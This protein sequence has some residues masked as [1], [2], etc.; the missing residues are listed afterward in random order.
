[1][2]TL[3]MQCVVAILTVLWGFLAVQVWRR[4]PTAPELHRASWALTGWVFT[5]LGISTTIQLG[6]GAPW[7]YFSGE[8]STVY[9]LYLRLSP[10]G[11]HSRGFLVI[12]YGVM[13]AGLPW[14]WRVARHRF[15]AVV[16]LASCAAM[17]V[18]ALVGWV[19]G[20]LV[21]VIHWTATAIFDSVELMLLLLAL[22]VAVVWNT[23]D[24]LLWV[25]LAIFAVHE[26]LDVAWYS[27]LAWSDVAGAWSPKPRYIH[28]YASLAYLLMI[29]VSV[30]RMRLADKE[31]EVG[32]FI[33]P[34]DRIA[35]SLS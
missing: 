18:G 1:M 34:P 21:Q 8:G 33:E 20:P 9:E 24:R 7:A 30:R 5:I 31:V 3:W 12:A 10:I 32:G 6:I 17:T 13:L 29:I 19:E 22:F 26:M 4:I 23:T 25:A 27:A 16:L 28:M 15:F 2:V 35:T 11:N 14:I